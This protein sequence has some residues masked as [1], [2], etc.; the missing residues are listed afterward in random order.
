MND[1][2]ELTPL[3]RLLYEVDPVGLAKTYTVTREQLEDLV[4]ACG[5][6]DYDSGYEDGWADGYDEAR[7]DAINKARMKK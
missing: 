5:P 7:L 1:K 6:E 2:M 4:E 3:D